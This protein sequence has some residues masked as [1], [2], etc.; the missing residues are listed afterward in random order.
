MYRSI[1]AGFALLVAVAACDRQALA[2]ESPA[3]ASANALGRQGA[4]VRVPIRGSLV[5][6][7]NVDQSPEAVAQCPGTPGVAVGVAQGEMAHLGTL[8]NGSFV[9]CS[10]DLSSLLPPNPSPPALPDIH[11]VGDFEL[12]AADGN[13][14]S[15]SYEFVFAPADQGGFFNMTILAGTGRLDGASGW[16][17]TDF[18]RTPLV[19]CDDP[20]CL[21]NTRFEP[22]L[23]GELVLPRPGP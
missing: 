6:V 23:V 20:L 16:L 5:M 17:E 10:I 2:P 11:R 14:L 1:L 7:H 3:P 13:T 15:G 4:T 9:H 12:V 8:R 18:D 19:T 22:V 21:V